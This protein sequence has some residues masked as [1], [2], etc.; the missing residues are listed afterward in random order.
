MYKKYDKT[1]INIF[2]EIV[3]RP[4]TPLYVYYFGFAKI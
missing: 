1:L 3:N 4:E 2:Y